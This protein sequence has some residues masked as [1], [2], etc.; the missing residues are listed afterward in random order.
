M[1][2]FSGVFYHGIKVSCALNSALNKKRKEEKAIENANENTNEN[3]NNTMVVEYHA[4]TDTSQPQSPKP[5][6]V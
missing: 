5:E 3:I 6:Q 2:F 4:D 1:H